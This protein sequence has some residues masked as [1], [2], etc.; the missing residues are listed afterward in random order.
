[1][2]GNG[3]T[4]PTGVLRVRRMAPPPRPVIRNLDDAVRYGTP[5]RNLRFW[6]RMAAMRRA[7]Q[8]ENLINFDRSLHDQDLFDQGKLF[9]IGHL[10]LAV[11]RKDGA[12][13]DLGLAS[14]R[15]VTD[16]GVGFI[17]D[18]FQ[19]LTELETMKFHA[20]GTGT[21]AEAASQTALV[22]ELTTQYSVS[23]TRPT[24][25]TGEKSGD[26]K[27]YETTAT[28]TVSTTVAATEHAIMSQAATG[29]GVM[30]DRS[31]FSVV[32]LASAESI[33]A[34]YQLTFPSA[35]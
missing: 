3:S 13:E 17:V 30:L 22:T 19:N 14:C 11:Y 12:V 1:V 9:A 33:A 29:G 7:W 16:T 20:L 32:N 31:V 24:G 8:G 27:T 4:T 2:S 34:T 35:G 25:T 18:A 23:N 15:V 28:I 6:D 10:W 26:A 21:T 5:G